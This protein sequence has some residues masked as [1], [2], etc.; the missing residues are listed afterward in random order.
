MANF[1]GCHQ[2]T[3]RHAKDS[4]AGALYLCEN[5]RMAD[6]PVNTTKQVPL[7]T[8]KG[9]LILGDFSQV[10]LGIWSELDILV[11]PFDSTAYARGGYWSARWQP[12][13]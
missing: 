2:E 9:Q 4:T 10:L 1:P 7:A 6:L 11:N 8:A 5:N 12:A 13:T 3:A